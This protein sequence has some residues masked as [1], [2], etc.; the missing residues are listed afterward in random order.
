MLDPEP[1]L[2]RE[3]PGPRGKPLPLTL[4]QCEAIEEAIR[5]GKAE[6][7]VVRR[8]Q[9]ALLMAAGVSI[10]DTA[11]AVGVEIRTVGRW[12]RRFLNAA[13]PVAALADA[14][15]SGRPISLFRTQTRRG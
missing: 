12:R 11:K 2:S 6:Q 8:G 9:A 5:P 4:D 13:D 3:H 1:W 14:P 7:R 15:R 10:C